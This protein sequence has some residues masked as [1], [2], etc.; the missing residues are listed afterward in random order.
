MVPRLRAFDEVWSADGQKLGV[1]RC[2]HYRPEEQ[3][4]IGTQL[5]PVYLE[6]ESFEL[7]DDFFIPV[8]LLEG[9]DPVGD[10]VTVA[11][12]LKAIMNRTLNRMPD[13]VAKMESRVEMLP[14]ELDE[15]VVD[16]E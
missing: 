4:D 14:R 7:G 9:R 10:R 2:L 3:V 13:F 15:E 5:Y 11:L 8:H 1:A 16:V 6:V 12:K